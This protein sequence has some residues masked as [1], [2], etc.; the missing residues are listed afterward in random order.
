MYF[1]PAY[2]LTTEQK[3]E[4]KLKQKD[5]AKKVTK[6]IKNRVYVVDDGNYTRI[7]F[8]I[9][10]VLAGRS[11]YDIHC[12]RLNVEISK[13]EERRYDGEFVNRTLYKDERV[14]KYSMRKYRSLIEQ[15]LGTFLTIFGLSNRYSSNSAY[16]DL[17]TPKIINRR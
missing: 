17:E 8:R 16:Y 5:Y 4:C 11:N 2:N 7:T 12:Y 3:K 15:E 10:S 14:R 13:I 9:V 6:M 1:G